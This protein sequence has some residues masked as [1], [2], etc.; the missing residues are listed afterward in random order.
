MKVALALVSCCE[1]SVSGMHFHPAG[2][3]LSEH[4]PEMLGHIVH[5]S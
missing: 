1:L 5:E 4:L 3:S 2:L